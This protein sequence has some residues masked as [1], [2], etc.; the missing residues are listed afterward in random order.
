VLHVINHPLAQD[1]LTRL[2]N[3]KTV[4]EGFRRLVMQLAQILVLEATRDIKLKDVEVETP[5]AKTT[6]KKL[7]EAVTLVPIMRAGLA[8]VEGASGI[9]PSASVGHIGIYRD[10][11]VRNTIEYYFR[12]PANVKDT[13]VLVLDPMLATGDTACAAISRL[14]EYDVKHI[15]FLCILA[16]TPGVARIQNEHPDVRIFTLSVEPELNDQGYMLP[17]VGDAGDRIYGTVD[18]D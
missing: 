12:L 7:A 6:G 8:M 18:A 4:P 10:K 16:A 1:K 14:K 17:G 15:D 3:K 9:L 5:L 11:F 2:R 13:R